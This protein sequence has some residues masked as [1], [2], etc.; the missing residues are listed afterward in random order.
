MAH[1]LNTGV[2]ATGRVN[3]RVTPVGPLSTID[4]RA[5]WLKPMADAGQQV[6]ARVA[7]GVLCHEALNL[8]I[9]AMSAGGA[10]DGGGSEGVE[11]DAR[12]ASTSNTPV[13]FVPQ[14]QLPPGEAYE[15]YIFNSRLCPTR[16]GLH[17]FFNGLCWIHFQATKKRL[18]Q[19]QAQQ[20]EQDGIGQQ[21]GAVRDA[22]TVF[23]ENAAFLQAPDAL[24]DA[25]VAKDWHML[26]VTLRP[27]WAEAHLVLFGHALLEKLV[28]PRKAMTAHVYRAYPASKSIAFLD[29]WIAADLSS[30]K[31]ARKPFAH[32]P[33]LGVPG[34]WPANG[35]PGF[36]NDSSVFRAPRDRQSV[37]A[38]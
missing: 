36:Y 5:P 12:P 26:F 32:L 7:A 18:N 6:A 25:L 9:D 4:W 10:E 20:I 11:W 21:R 37:P 19:L 14:S 13:R 22:L 30:E 38:P 33:V 28:A 15:K 1:G 35:K 24:W 27:M 34:W 3:G 23:D 31:L 17:D 29:A 16:E 8:H 2:S